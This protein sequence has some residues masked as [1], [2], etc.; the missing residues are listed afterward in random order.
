MKQ[1]EK[2]DFDKAKNFCDTAAADHDYDLY[3]VSWVV[4]TRN[5][6]KLVFAA[7]TLAV[8]RYPDA[9]PISCIFLSYENL[10]S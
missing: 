5:G 6:N 9:M 1:K 7:F 2:E 10:L 8:W 4:S 3:L